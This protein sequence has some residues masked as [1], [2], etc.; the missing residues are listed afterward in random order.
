MAQATLTVLAD[1]PIGTISPL[2]HGQFAEHLGRCC[3]DGLWVGPDSTIPNRAGFRTDVLDALRDLRIPILRWPGGCYADVYH[4]RD[5]IGPYERRPRTLGESCGLQ[6]VE[7]NALGTHEFVALCREIGAEPYLAGNMGS[8]TPQELADWVHYCNGKLDTTRVRERAANGH[9]E[10][11]SVRYW[12]V[13]NENWGC[14]GNMDPVDYAREFIRHATFIERTDPAV[15]MVA[16]GDCRRD[17]NLRV[18]ETLRNNIGFLNH[19]SVHQYYIAGSGTGFSEAEYYK[20]MRAGDL[21]DEDI[22]F[23]DEILRFF[24]AGRRKV[25]I[26]FDEWGVW[27]P[28][29][30]GTCNYEAPNTLRDAIAAAGVLDVFHRWCNE[31]SM[32]NM[33]QIV[34]VL[35]CIVQ[36]DGPAMWLTPT[37]HLFR[38]YKPH[39]G[40]T[41]V[42]TTLE[43]PTT[44]APDLG[45]LK[46]GQ[47]ALASASA[48]LR[49]GRL[50]VSLTNRHRREPLD[51]TVKVRGA[52]IPSEA[53]VLTGDPAATNS[54][55]DPERVVIQTIALDERAESVFHITLPACSVATV[56]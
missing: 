33:A 2:I 39:R 35:Q 25:G 28:E 32:A 50:V 37:Y 40:A 56:V 38:L 21:V 14:G 6:V 3:N 11:M 15:E 4:W 7:D 46:A 49:E 16:C 36:T 27:H 30:R 22:R 42:R 44:D 23:T 41:A 17:W 19:L 55:D 10:P 1:E 31:I 34:N 52:A 9:P 13:G 43:S 47:V 24:A 12:G 5:G 53:Q 48:S 54:A 26:A 20:I 18:V 29:C 45:V 8:G 51:V